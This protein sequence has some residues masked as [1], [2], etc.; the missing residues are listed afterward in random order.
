MRRLS[1]VLSALVPVAFAT[2]LALAPLAKAD[3][4]VDRANALIGKIPDARRSD[5][6][7]LPLVAKMDKPPE[8]VSDKGGSVLYDS[9]APGWSTY[10]EWADK[11]AQRAVIDAFAAHPA[12]G[13]LKLDGKM[14]DRPHLVQARRIVALAERSR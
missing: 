12:A 11:P 3:E 1:T 10:V 6:V 2:A 4:Y 13:A 7:V 8:A 14:I 9:T 5:L